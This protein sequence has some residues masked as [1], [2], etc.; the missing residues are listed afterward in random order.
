MTVGIVITEMSTASMGGGRTPIIMLYYNYTAITNQHS[1]LFHRVSPVVVRVS[2]EQ[3]RTE[4][5]DNNINKT[6]H[7]VRYTHLML[8]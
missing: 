3:I 5:F 8:G 7:E 2:S 6:V 4:R 1:R